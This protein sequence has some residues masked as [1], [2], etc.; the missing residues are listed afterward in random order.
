MCGGNT[1][2]NSTLVT[3]DSE[4]ETASYDYVITF[5]AIFILP[6][7]TLLLRAKRRKD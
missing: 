1:N 4:S 7:T 2:L 3:Y 6:V 5:F